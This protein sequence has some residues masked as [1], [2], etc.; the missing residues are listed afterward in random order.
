MNKRGFD[1]ISLILRHQFFLKN[2]TPSIPSRGI[3]Q[4]IDKL[5]ESEPY[6]HHSKFDFFGWESDQAISSTAQYGHKSSD[7]N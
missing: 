5:F 6:P 7:Q 1:F 4:S 2:H 3:D